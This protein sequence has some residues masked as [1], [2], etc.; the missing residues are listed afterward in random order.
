MNLLTNFTRKQA[1]AIEM[2]ATR[3]DINYA[4]IA[5]KLGVSRMTVSTWKRNPLFW[6]AVYTRYMQYMEGKLPKVM[7]AMVR[8]ACEGNVQAAK[9]VMESAGKLIKRVTLSVDSP[10]EKFLKAESIEFKDIT[11]GEIQDEDFAHLPVRNSTNDHP[12]RRMRAEKKKI[13]QK[14][15][16]YKGKT[17]YATEQRQKRQKQRIVLRKRAIDVGL[18]PLI[19]KKPT[20][21]DYTAWVNKI[22]ELEEQR[23]IKYDNKDVDLYIK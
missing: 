16:N 6:S 3:P 18:K 17:K 15:S 21:T 2:I 4:K 7:D 23:G 10:F 13:K 11:D 12:V 5:D 9:L 14:L 1:M 8:E 19:N 22:V 20:K